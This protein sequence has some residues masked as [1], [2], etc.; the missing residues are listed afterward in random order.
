[1]IVE[2]VEGAMSRTQS[3]MVSLGSTAPAF[4]LWM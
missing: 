2:V 3:T 1:M 4:E